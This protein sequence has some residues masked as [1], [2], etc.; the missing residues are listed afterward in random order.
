MA[1]EFEATWCGTE[2]G[3]YRPC[4]GTYEYYPYHTLPIL[5]ASRFTGA[6]DWIPMHGMVAPGQVA[7]LADLDRQLAAVGLA[8]PIDFVKYHSFTDLSQTLVA[9]SGTGCW[10]TLLRPNPD[11]AE[12]LD[13]RSRN[14]P[15]PSPAEPGAF[16]IRFLIG[17]QDCV[18]WYL[19]LRPTGE[20]FVVLAYGLEFEVDDDGTPAYLRPG[21]FPSFLYPNEYGG[22]A[23]IYWCAPSF[24]VF[25]YRF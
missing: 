20:T 21:T 11:E 12:E 3:D 25:A 22:F 2:L 13:L 8:L 4:G 15:I 19:Y 24:E 6:F 9:V 1:V 14:Y 10:T 17:Q 18:T 16:L 5:D 7:L 23:K